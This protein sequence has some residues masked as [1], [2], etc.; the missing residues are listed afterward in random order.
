MTGVAMMNQHR[1]FRLNSQLFYYSLI[2]HTHTLYSSGCYYSISSTSYR[3]E[4]ENF[5]QN[6]I[7]VHIFESAAK[8]LTFDINSKFKRYIQTL[9]I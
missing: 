7:N 9:Y 6:E 2:S 3:N 4:P 5:I 8:Y 1:S